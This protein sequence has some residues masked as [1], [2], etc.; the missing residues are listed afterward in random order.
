MEEVVLEELQI[1]K[2]RQSRVPEETVKLASPWYRTVCLNT[3]SLFLEK[4]EQLAPLFSF[5]LSNGKKFLQQPRAGLPFPCRIPLKSGLLGLPLITLLSK[6]MAR[7]IAT[8][9]ENLGSLT[10]QVLFYFIRLLF[11]VS[12]NEFEKTGRVCK[13]HVPCFSGIIFNQVAWQ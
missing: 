3:S 6:H 12:S 4:S 7:Q 2:V 5:S 1:F 9:D 11:N 8:V 13:S 10:T